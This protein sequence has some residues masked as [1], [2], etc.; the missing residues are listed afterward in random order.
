MRY[1]TKANNFGMWHPDFVSSDV[2]DIDYKYLK[3]NGIDAIAFDVD[4][5][6]TVN[7]SH[8]IDLLRAKKLIEVLDKANLNTRFLA[9]NSIRDLNEIANKLQGFKIHQPHT[10]SGKP[11]KEFYKQL[12]HKANTKPKNMAMVGDRA[13]Q[14]IWAAKR[15][16]LT[17][18]LVELNPKYCT[19]KDK[20]L[21]RHLWQKYLVRLK[22]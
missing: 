10:H 3:K 4:G 17:T 7:G 9:S 19:A 13:I 6:L 11:S 18:V 12:L 15:I 22:R 2:L 20:L 14:D 5:T 21:L 1:F 8:S 16:G